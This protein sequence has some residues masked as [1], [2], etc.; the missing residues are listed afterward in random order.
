MQRSHEYFMKLA[1]KEAVYAFE[2]DEVPIGAV[3]VCKNQVIGKGYNQVEK[4]T[5]VTAHAEMIAITAAS[6]YLGSKFLEECEIYVTVEPC[7][8]CA[9]ALRWARIGKIIYGTGEPKT[10]FTAFQKTVLHPTTEIVGGVLENECAELMRQFF[11]GK[12]L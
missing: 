8:M 5:D 4:L 1:L 10:G 7:L 2:E 3:V 6:N 9:T 12:R 11:K